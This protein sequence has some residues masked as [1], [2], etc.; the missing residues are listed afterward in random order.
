M[1]NKTLSVDKREKLINAINET[2]DFLEE[3]YKSNKDG[4]IKI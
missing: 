1:G 3:G 4:I 2:Y